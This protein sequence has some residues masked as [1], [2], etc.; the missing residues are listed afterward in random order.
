MG[1]PETGWMGGAS[2]LS[3]NHM[4]WIGYVSGWAPGVEITLAGG[5]GAGAGAGAGMGAGAAAGA[6]GKVGSGEQNGWVTYR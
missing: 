1:P 2:R 5:A 3:G 6:F 4:F